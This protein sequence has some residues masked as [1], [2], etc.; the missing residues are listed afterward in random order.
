M[1]MANETVTYYHLDDDGNAVSRTVISGAS[2]YA[3]TVATVSNKSVSLG[4]VI[5]CRIPT[6]NAPEDFIPC[7]DDMLVLGDC[8][9]PIGT[10]DADLRGTYNAVTI[11]AVHDNRRGQGAHWK[12]E[13][14]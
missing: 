2:W 7:E 11:S 3:H 12:L 6:D 4:K 1:Q 8:D 9:A 10:N 5:Q 13:A 14:V